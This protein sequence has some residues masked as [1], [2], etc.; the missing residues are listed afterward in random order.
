M[1]ELES[2]SRRRSSVLVLQLAPL[3][4]VFVLIIVFLL[5]GTILED[6][7]VIRPSDINLAKSESR[8]TTD[9]SPVVI[10]R[11]DS[12]EFTMLGRTVSVSEFLSDE[13]PERS[14]LQNDLA[15]FLKSKSALRDGALFNLNVVADQATPYRVLYNVVKV[16]RQ[17]GFNSMLLVAEGKGT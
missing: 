11:A 5:K 1:Y 16:L 3:I 4:D 10:L 2:S 17:A 15:E 9:L 12:V 7:A 13:L 14:T 8:E 6:V